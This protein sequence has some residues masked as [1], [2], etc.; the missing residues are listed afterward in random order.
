MST[1]QLPSHVYVGTYTIWPSAPVPAEGIYLYRLDPQNGGLTLSGV[2]A[3]VVNPSYL[4]LAPGQ[5][6]LYAVNEVGELAG[7]A[8]GGISAF[9]VDSTTGALTYVNRQSTHGVDPCH[10]SVDST[11]RWVGVANYTSGSIALF[12]VGGNGE[13]LPASDFHQH[14]GGSILRRQA[15]PHAHSINL[16]PGN[17]FAIVCDLGLD[18]VLTYQLDRERGKLVKVADVSVAPGSGPRHF[19]F[20]PDGRHAYLINEISSTVTAFTYDAATGQ[21]NPLQTVSTLPTDFVGSNSTADIH[22][23]PNGKFLYGSNR[24]HDSIAIFAIDVATGELTPVGHESTRGHTPRNFAIDPT[25]TFLLAANQDTGNVAAFRVD[26][27]RGTLTLSAESTVPTPV[28][29]KFAWF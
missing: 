1:N 29:L 23:H 3:G 26:P 5:R 19:T 28:C 13:V 2:T 17:R 9:A 25:G 16:D 10:V 6:Y 12:A 24:G 21:L 4:A 7:Q 18:Q 27:N 15:G 8:G 20:H 11:G 22:V 14:V